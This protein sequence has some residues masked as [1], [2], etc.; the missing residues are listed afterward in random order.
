MKE[1]VISANEAGQRLDKLLHKLLPKAPDPF[2]YKMLRRKNITRNGAR[3]AGN[4]RL[5]QGDVIRL[6]FSDETLAKFGSGGSG[7]AQEKSCRDAFARLRG[8]R[9]CYEDA[10]V[11]LL[12]KP[13]GILSQKA[14]P[15]DLSLNEWLIGYLLQTGKTT[16]ERLATFRPSVCNRLDRNTSG[17]VLCGVSLAGSRQ[18]SLLLR[19]RRVRKEYRLLVLGRP[20][21]D[22]QLCGYLRRDGASGVSSVL[23]REEAGALSEEE[24]RAC[25]LIQ[26]DYRRIESVR[27]PESG[28]ELSLLEARLHTGKTHQIRAQLAAA[29]YPLLGDGKYGG[30][31]AAA[32]A[33]LRRY[34]VRYQLLHAFR[35]GFPALPEPFSALS[36]A[37]L[38]DPQPPLYDRI[39]SELSEKEAAER[40]AYGDLEL[41]GAS[42]LHAGRPHQPHQ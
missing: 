11:M 12:H 29:G 8:V 38:T 39:L 36:G 23:T 4:E 42:R 2:L 17:L 21:Q 31:P 28:L 18:M 41:A 5:S 14:A 15:G 10:H 9:V 16:P 7:G 37:V 1:I 13:A 30:R 6:F 24:R 27:C 25:S 26:T 20:P 19:E 40:R 32:E 3:A 33:I 22:M 35:L 34:D